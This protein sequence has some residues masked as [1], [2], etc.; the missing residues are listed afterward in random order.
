MLVVANLAATV[1][2]FVLLRE[3]VFSRPP[4]CRAPAPPPPIAEEFSVTTT[5]DPS[6]SGSALDRPPTEPVDRRDAAVAERRGVRWQRISLVALLAGTAL[7]YLVGAIGLGEPVLRRRCAGRDA[8]LEGLPFGSL[9][10]A[11]FITVDKPPARCG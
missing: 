9:D 4:S 2:R 3:W 7:L 1:L 8:E 5:Y 6:P 11:N 10:S